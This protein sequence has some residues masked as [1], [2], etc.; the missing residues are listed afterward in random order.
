MIPDGDD[1]PAARRRSSGARSF[2]GQDRERRRS[3]LRA[4]FQDIK[5]AVGSAVAKVAGV[6]GA[7]GPGESSSTPPAS[8]EK[9]ES[10]PATDAPPTPSSGSEPAPSF[11]ARPRQKSRR[12]SYNFGALT[13]SSPADFAVKAAAGQAT[14]DERITQSHTAASSPASEAPKEGAGGE[15]RDPVIAPLSP[16]PTAATTPPASGG[17][18][19][20][21][22]ASPSS[23]GTRSAARVLPAEPERTPAAGAAEPSAPL[24]GG[25]SGRPLSTAD[26][27]GAAPR[28]PEGGA[29][30]AEQEKAGDGGASAA[31]AADAVLVA[32]VAGTTSAPADG[33]DEGVAAAATVAAAK[34]EPPKKLHVRRG[35][36]VAYDKTTKTFV[37]LGN[38][39]DGFNTPPSPLQIARDAGVASMRDMWGVDA[40]DNDSAAASARVSSDDGPA[41]ASPSPPPFDGASAD[42]RG[43]EDGGYKKRRSGSV[44]SIQGMWGLVETPATAAADARPTGGGPV[45]VTADA[46]VAVGSHA[47]SGASDGGGSG[48]TRIAR[49]GAAV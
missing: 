45:V 17:A 41:A 8:P 44:T 24:G 49:N 34:A 31:G 6:G 25:A 28:L 38:D 32:G 20:P 2:L 5:N 33:D 15:T 1:V 37:Q 9:V 36:V 27:A 4:S 48:R 26:S 35:S 29:E 18:K 47:S 30:Q 21:P 40:N 10:D 16:S 7:N 12:G 23:P 43:D 3:S 39:G 13:A 42:D 11:A 22:M 19:L 14:A 46:T